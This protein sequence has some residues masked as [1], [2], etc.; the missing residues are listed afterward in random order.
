MQFDGGIGEGGRRGEMKQQVK[1]FY[2][3]TN[4]VKDGMVSAREMLKKVS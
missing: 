2:N 4:T 1:E 3:N